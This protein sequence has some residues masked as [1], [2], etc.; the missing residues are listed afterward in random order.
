[1]YFGF[2]NQKSNQAI[3]CLRKNNLGPIISLYH[4]A[5]V[6][7]IYHILPK[8]AGLIRISFAA[9]KEFFK[10]ESNQMTCPQCGLANNP[11]T[12]ACAQCGIIFVKNNDMQT[13]TDRDEQKRKAIEE[14]EAI[15]AQ[16]DPGAGNEPATKEAVAGP[17]PAEDTVEMAI[18]VEHQAAE[19]PSEAPSTDVAQPEENQEPATDEIELEAIETSIEMV[20]TDAEELFLS[21]VETNNPF[22]PQKPAAV[23]QP[24]DS[25]TQPE[26]AVEQSDKM[27][28][29]DVAAEEKKAEKKDDT[30]LKQTKAETAAAA[31]PEEDPQKKEPAETKSELADPEKAGATELAKAKT[32]AAEIAEPESI[33]DK[34]TATALPAEKEIHPEEKPELTMVKDQPV[35]D[36]AQPYPDATIEIPKEPGEENVPAKSQEVVGKDEAL[37]RQQETQVKEALQKQGETQ[38]QAEALKKQIAAK[39][40]AAVLKKKKLAQVKAEALKK[41]KAA[42]HKAEAAKKNQAQAKAKPAQ[43]QKTVWTEAL[44]KQ[45][46]A[47]AEAEASTQDIEIASSGVSE[48]ASQTS[49]ASLSNHAK[50]LGLLKK[51]KGKAIGINYDN[52]SEIKAAE[53]VDANEEFFSVRVTDQKLQYSYPLK[54]IL[55]IVEGQEGVETGEDDKKLKFDA[56]IKVYPLVPF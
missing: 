28:K 44:K 7:K 23:E 38:A 32:S 30:A 45:K 15:L 13:P 47:Q 3:Y 52:S 19:T 35:Q 42:L 6:L 20:T 56:V 31:Q 26:T 1:V 11:L 22:E 54:N 34:A 18:P 33:E 55:T 53:L 4:S 43:K 16:I 9:R 39:A 41:Q 24:A 48:T 36:K 51:Y 27:V 14:A 12:E 21:E 2:T 10:M 50:L 25:T 17:D 46:E 5:L 29:S 37:K 8:K 49:D 40:K